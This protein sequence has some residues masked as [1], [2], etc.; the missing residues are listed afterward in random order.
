MHSAK[1]WVFAFISPRVQ[2]SCPWY[3]AVYSWYPEP[4]GVQILCMGKLVIIMGSLK[5]EVFLS[6]T[7]VKR[8]CLLMEFSEI[9]INIRKQKIKMPP[10]TSG[11]CPIQNR[12]QV[13]SVFR[14]S[15]PG[16]PHSLMTSPECSLEW[17]LC[18]LSPLLGPKRTWRKTYAQSYWQVGFLEAFLSFSSS[19]VQGRR[20]VPFPREVC[21]ARTVCLWFCWICNSNLFGLLLFQME[22]EEQVIAYL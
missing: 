14:V 12:E 15:V 19:F 13:D 10:I 16:S 18:L 3:L 11:P 21:S 17:H 9:R 1:A 5:N 22:K 20:Q 2:N 8:C 4:D 7:L 6:R